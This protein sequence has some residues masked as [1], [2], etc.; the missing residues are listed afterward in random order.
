VPESTAW[1]PRLSV[2]GLFCVPPEG[3][4]LHPT[5][6]TVSDAAIDAT[7]H[8]PRA[9]LHDEPT[10]CRAGFPAILMARTSE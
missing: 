9:A 3:G 10:T 5:I 6:D 2:E 7:T 8:A 4:E 1:T